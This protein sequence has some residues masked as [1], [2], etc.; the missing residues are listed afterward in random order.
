MHVCIYVF[1]PVWQDGESSNNL[2]YD[3]NGQLRNTGVDGLS[4]GIRPTRGQA[5]NQNLH[6]GKY[7]N[8]NTNNL[9]H[10][11]GEQAYDVTNWGIVTCHLKQR[12]IVTKHIQNDRSTSRIL[13]L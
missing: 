12:G 5:G 3:E 2:I 11:C 7:L 8:A 4:L 10:G 13:A 9:H 6:I 1:E